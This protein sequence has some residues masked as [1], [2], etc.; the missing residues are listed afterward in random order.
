MVM[1]H[2]MKQHKSTQKCDEKADD[3]NFHPGVN[4]QV[5]AD[6]LT[7]ASHGRQHNAALPQGLNQRE[8]IELLLEQGLVFRRAP[9]HQ[10]ER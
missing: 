7:L 4:H 10:P 9:A 5:Q 6:A 1:A 3:R 8:L 2:Q